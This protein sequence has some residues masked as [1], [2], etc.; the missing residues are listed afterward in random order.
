LRF[1]PA[2]AAHNVDTGR[3]EADRQD[4][5]FISPLVALRARARNSSLTTRDS[6]R[7]PRP[8]IP[9]CIVPIVLH[10]LFP[11]ILAAQASQPDW[12]KVEEETLRHFQALLRMDTSD[13]PGSI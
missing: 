8:R 1:K 2:L 12:T 3:N 9:V 5:V 11:S 6:S 7:R 4:S 10:F 13:P